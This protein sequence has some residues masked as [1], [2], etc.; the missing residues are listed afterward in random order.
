MDLIV[1]GIVH[2]QDFISGNQSKHINII[3]LILYG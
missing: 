2:Y 1:Y 3:D